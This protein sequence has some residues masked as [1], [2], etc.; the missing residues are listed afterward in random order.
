MDDQGNQVTPNGKSD[1]SVRPD[2]QT[3]V[4]T[5][6]MY[7]VSMSVILFLSAQV[8]N[9]NGNMSRLLAKQEAQIMWNSRIERAIERLDSKFDNLAVHPNHQGD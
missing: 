1:S 8:W 4:V 2:H 3:K 6:W 7:A 5:G 9:M